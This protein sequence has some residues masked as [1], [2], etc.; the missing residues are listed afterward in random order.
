MV[1]LTVDKFYKWLVIDGNH[2][3]THAI[4][5]SIKALLLP[6]DVLNERNF[7]STGFDKFLYFFKM[8]W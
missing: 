4:E 3:I 5:K 2:R 8:K 6:H 7:F 1:P